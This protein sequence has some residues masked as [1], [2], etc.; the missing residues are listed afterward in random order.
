MAFPTD[1]FF[2]TNLKKY[3]PTAASSSELH[4]QI[5]ISI[6]HYGVVAPS[7]NISPHGAPQMSTCS[8]DHVAAVNETPYS[9]GDLWSGSA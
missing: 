1:F 6:A 5:Y 3:N 4:K 9:H 2:H 7:T 8:A